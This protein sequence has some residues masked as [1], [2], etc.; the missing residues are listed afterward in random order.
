[1]ASKALFVQKKPKTYVILV[2]LD[3]SDARRPI[4]VIHMGGGWAL[5]V[6]ANVVE[7]G[8]GHPG[9]AVVTPED[10]V[11]LVFCVFRRLASCSG[12]LT[13]GDRSLSLS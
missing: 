7:G 8:S 6:S 5:L 10:R 4:A 11:F 2:Q 3:L 12:S 9:L 13:R 1:M